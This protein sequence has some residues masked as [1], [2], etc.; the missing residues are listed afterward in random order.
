MAA[1]GTAALFDRS[2]EARPDRAWAELRQ[3]AATGHAPRLRLDVE[4]HHAVFSG[5]DEAELDRTIKGVAR[6][7]SAGAVISDTVA[8]VR[9]RFRGAVLVEATHSVVADRRRGEF[10]RVKLLLWSGE[11][12][13]GFRFQSRAR[14]DAVPPRFL[15]PIS[16]ALRL[17]SEGLFADLHAALISCAWH[18]EDSSPDAFERA[19]GAALRDPQVGQM[20][21]LVEPVGL[22]KLTAPEAAADAVLAEL[23]RRGTVRHADAAGAARAVLA[24]APAS[25]LIGLTQRLAGIAHEPI[26]CAMS[27]ARY[28]PIFEPRAEAVEPLPEGAVEIGALVA[29]AL[30]VAFPVGVATVFEAKAET[31]VP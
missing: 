29:S 10:A 17:A 7:L 8:A 30:G 15:P 9:L 13:D 23:A 2:I 24:E 25:R 1:L 14:T 6:Q 11:A 31:L 4:R 21:E 5:V 26:D 20:C 19:A 28:R 16:R 12:G 22:V 18:D 3:L 27:L